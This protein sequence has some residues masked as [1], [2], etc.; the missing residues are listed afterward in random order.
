MWIRYSPKVRSTPDCRSAKTGLRA[1]RWAM[2]P[3]DSNRSGLAL[4]FELSGVDDDETAEIAFPTC[5]V[6]TD[7]A[8]CRGSAPANPMVRDP[9]LVGEVTGWTISSLVNRRTH[10]LLDILIVERLQGR[11]GGGVPG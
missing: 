10:F 6:P 3:R 8:N 2:N 5:A 11:Q 7:G 1:G 4:V 9:G